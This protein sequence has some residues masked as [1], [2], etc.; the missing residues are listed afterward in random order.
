[1]SIRETVKEY[2]ANIAH[3]VR[4]AKLEQLV[5]DVAEQLAQDVAAADTEDE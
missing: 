2:L 5:G 4:T 3:A 1:M